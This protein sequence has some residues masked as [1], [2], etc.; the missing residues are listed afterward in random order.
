[1]KTTSKLWIWIGVL[2]V[3]SPLGIVMPQF[4]RSQDAWGEWG[5]DTLKELVGYIPQGLHKVATLWKAPLPDYAPEGWGE[6]SVGIVSLGY[7]LSA[8]AGVG[9][10]VCVAMFIGRFL[11]KKEK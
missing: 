9:M 4:F 11:S 6:K 8:L 10:T 2:I 1:M 7:I 5:V 3:V